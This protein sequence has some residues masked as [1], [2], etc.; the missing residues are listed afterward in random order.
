MANKQMKRCSV[1]LTIQQM[2]AFR[3]LDIIFIYG[4]LEKNL[5]CDILNDYE[6]IKKGQLLYLANGNINSLNQFGKQI[7]N[8]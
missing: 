4:I 1:S 3:K 2:Q 8:L 5:N 6:K 7:L